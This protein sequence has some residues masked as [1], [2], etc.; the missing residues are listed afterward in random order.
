MK[1]YTVTDNNKHNKV[2]VVKSAYYNAT[3]DRTVITVRDAN[4]N[5]V[6]TVYLKGGK[7]VQPHLKDGLMIA[8]NTTFTVENT[9][10]DGRKYTTDLTNHVTFGETIR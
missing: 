7:N 5:H 9:Y 2:A 3:K 1:F 10:L 4:C 8:Y 6:T